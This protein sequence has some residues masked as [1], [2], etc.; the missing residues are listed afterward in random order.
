[1]D[2]VDGQGRLTVGVLHP[3]QMGAAVAAAIAR[4]HH[5]LWCDAGRSPATAARAAA[6]GLQAVPD[7]ATLLARAD[8]VLS[9]CPPAAADAIAEQVLGF[10][11]VFVEA[12]AVSP[13]RVRA[14]AR[15]VGGRVVDGS[16]IGPAPTGGRTA[17]LHL[18]GAPADVDVVAGL[19]A[20]GPVQAVLLGTEIGA[21]SA[22]KMAFGSY[23]KAS[24]ALA[25]VAHALADRHGV[26]EELLAEAARM[27]SDALADRGYVPSVAARA[28]RW[29]PEMHEAAVALA[30]AGLPSE[31]AE[32][33]AAVLRRWESDR[34]VWD[35]TVDEALRRL[36]P[37]SS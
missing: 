14:I 9:I 16:I 19:L 27:P 18:A 21:A 3:G 1:M 17:R 4:R 13:A 35:L 11:G 20:G 34:D 8:V 31:L 12:N 32:G 2:V 26:T 30:D 6:A 37:S 28:W 7:V 22:L 36:G 25:A 24:R 10:D 23:Q 33:A 29:A 15:T 5:V